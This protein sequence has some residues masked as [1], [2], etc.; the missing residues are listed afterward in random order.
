MIAVEAGHETI[1]LKA[2]ENL[3]STLATSLMMNYL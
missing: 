1:A 2:A 3:H